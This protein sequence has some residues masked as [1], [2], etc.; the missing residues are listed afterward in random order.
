MCPLQIQMFQLVYF[1]PLLFIKEDISTDLSPG[2][3]GINHSLSPQVWL[4]G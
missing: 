1:N 2:S 4:V 3:T